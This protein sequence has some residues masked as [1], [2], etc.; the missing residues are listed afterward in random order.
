MQS[1]DLVDTPRP[2]TLAELDAGGGLVRLEHLG[3]D[4]DIVAAVGEAPALVAV[5]APLA[6]ANERGQRDV[7]RV[8]GWCDIPVFPVSRRRMEQVHG[9]LRGVAIAAAAG[10]GDVELVETSPDLVLR[11]LAWEEQAPGPLD[12]GEYRARW[13]GLRAPAY[14]PKGPGRAKPAGLVA[15]HS[16]LARHVD[17]QGWALAEKPDDWAAIRDAAALDAIACAYVAWR[18][19]HEP[20]RVLRIGRADIGEML[21]PVD[22]NLAA[23]IAVNLERLRSEGAVGI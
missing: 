23:R 19:V 18:A 5:D 12:L 6:V 11:Q 8:L 4:A 14:R 2:S 17:L 22:E 20:G 16:L 7:E 9:G 1:L 15:A 13:I 3:G 21:V 10:R